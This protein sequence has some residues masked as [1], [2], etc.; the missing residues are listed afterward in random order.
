MPRPSPALDLLVLWHVTVT[1]QRLAMLG[2]ASKYNHIIPKVP[3]CR[4][5][6]VF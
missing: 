4:W 2:H 6:P 5:V 3:T 1:N